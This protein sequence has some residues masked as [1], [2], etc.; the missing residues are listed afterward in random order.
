MTLMRGK[1]NQEGWQRNHENRFILFLLLV[2]L[3]SRTTSL[4][5]ASDLVE[6]MLNNSD[7]PPVTRADG[8]VIR[9][10]QPVIHFNEVDECSGLDALLISRV[11]QALGQPVETTLHDIRWGGEVQTDKGEEFVWV[12]EISGAAP[13]AHHG[14]WQNSESYRQPAMYFPA[15]GGT[16]KG[17]AKPGHIIWSRIYVMDGELNFDIGLGE[18]V[19]LSQD[20]ITRRSE[21]TTREWPMMNAVLSGVSRDQMMAR[22][23]SNHVQV[24]YAHSSDEAQQA[25]NTRAALA[26]C[27]GIR[28][29]ICM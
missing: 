26:Q 23:K 28:T 3:K 25:L 29:Y 27:L 8:S 18:V 11:H 4:L 21:G 2:G 15:G 6:G 14:G 17:I 7:R 12:F 13:P 24:V 5:P 20:E 1:R 19:E 22:H 10:G 16:L 9:Q